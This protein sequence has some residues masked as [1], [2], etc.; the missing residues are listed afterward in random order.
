MSKRTKAPK[1]FRL[2]I[3][4]TVNAYGETIVEA[5]TAEEAQR[6]VEKSLDTLGWESPFWKRT[7]FDDIDWSEADDLRV[8]EGETKEAR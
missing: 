6:I 1:K 7:T 5:A 3:G 4:V 8:V 2:T